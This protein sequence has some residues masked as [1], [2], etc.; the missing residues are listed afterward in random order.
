LLLLPGYSTI[1]PV[2]INS[3]GWVAG[4]AGDPTTTGA[5]AV[6]WEPSGSSYT[7]INLGVIPGTTS[8]SA[9]GIDDQ[10][11]VIGWS[12][13]GGAF[14]TATAP[15]VWSQTGGLTNLS[16]QGFPNEFP[17]AISPGGTVATP[18]YW[19][20]LNDP[21]SVTKLAPPPP[22]FSGPGSY[23][24]AINDA[25]DQARF[26]I[27]TS[28]SF[29][30]YLFRYNH[31]GIWQQLWLSPTG[32]LAPSGI[33]SINTFGDVIAT[34]EGVGLVAYGPNELAQ[35]LAAKLS[36]A[37]GGQDVTIGGPSNEFGQI[38][39]QVIIGR[40]QRLV[41]LTEA[42]SCITNCSR[43]ASIQLVGKMLGFPR[44]QCTTQAS[45]SVTATLTVTDELG[46]PLAGAAVAGRFLDD[47]YLNELVAGVTNRKGTVKLTHKGPACVGA[48]ALL[49]D[50]VT[51]GSRRL[52]R[53]TGI[54]TNYVI[55]QP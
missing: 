22:G 1:T 2:G 7:I 26:Q 31:A 30:L 37:Y 41:R 43:V 52:D 13:T 8:S 34:V 36:L 17:L 14:P 39:T 42:V 24:A 33:G 46:K 16:A 9:A 54:L 10:G 23:P 20:R 35:P 5:R 25:G 51:Q 21:N 11:R 19:Y 3:S 53:T 38:L 12:T 45:N 47:Y 6:L 49:V 32:T 29:F 44:G 4:Y 15:F 28:S 27:S 50:N 48:I 18:G 55:P 40:S